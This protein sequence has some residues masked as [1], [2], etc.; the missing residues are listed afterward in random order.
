MTYDSLLEAFAFDYDQEPL[1][2]ICSCMMYCAKRNAQPLVQFDCRVEVW[3]VSQSGTRIVS[4]AFQLQLRLAMYNLIAWCQITRLSSTPFPS[5]PPPQQQKQ[6]PTARICFKTDTT[7]TNNNIH[8]VQWRCMRWD[9][10]RPTRVA[11]CLAR[12]VLQHQSN[13]GFCHGAHAASGECRHFAFHASIVPTL[14]FVMNDTMVGPIQFWRA[15][16]LRR[17]KITMIIPGGGGPFIACPASC[18]ACPIVRWSMCYM[19]RLWKPL[20]L[21]VYAIIMDAWALACSMFSF[22][23]ATWFFCPEGVTKRL[24]FQPTNYRW[25]SWLIR[26]ENHRDGLS[27]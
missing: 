7:T 4:P 3:F 11:P 21:A 26:M 24:M 13:L 5:S 8:N 9:I 12:N 17:M 6:E 19:N 18:V 15:S 20:N 27:V 10:Q 2:R 25:V 14:S 1:Y 22:G 16:C 23:S